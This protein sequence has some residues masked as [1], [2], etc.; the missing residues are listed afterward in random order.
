MNIEQPKECYKCKTNLCLTRELIKHPWSDEIIG[1][2]HICHTC[3]HWN[4]NDHM[5][6]EGYWKYTY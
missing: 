1:Y 3:F 4:N 2:K 5:Y 6:G